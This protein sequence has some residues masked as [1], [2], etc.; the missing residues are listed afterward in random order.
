MKNRLNDCMKTEYNPNERQNKK[1][2]SFR[3]RKIPERSA[4]FRFTL[5]YGAASR[6]T[7]RVRLL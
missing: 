4:S 2:A 1:S 7:E 3:K 5:P 6:I